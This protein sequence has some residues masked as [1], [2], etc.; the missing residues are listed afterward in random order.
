MKS[1][2]YRFSS[3]FTSIK[4]FLRFS[5]ARKG[6]PKV[7]MVCASVSILNKQL[8]K[9]DIVV[10][11]LGSF[12]MTHAGR[13]EPLFALVPEFFLLPKDSFGEQVAKL[14]RSSLM[15]SI[16]SFELDENCIVTERLDDGQLRFDQV[17]QLIDLRMSLWNFDQ[18]VHLL[19]QLGSQLHSFTVTIGFVFNHVPGRISRIKSV[20]ENF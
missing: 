2:P 10:Y 9:Y 17:Y 3:F 6:D 19:N 13:R 4:D 14:C 7:S 8:G 12:K 16:Q 18:C 1:F 15:R 5:T 20:S 11:I